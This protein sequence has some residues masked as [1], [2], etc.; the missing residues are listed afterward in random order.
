MKTGYHAVYENDFF[1][2]IDI[3]KDNGFEF[4]Q[5][6]LGV[7][8]FFLDDLNNDDLNEIKNYSKDKGIQLSFHA[9]GDNVSLFCDYPKIRKGNIGQFLSMLEKANKLDARHITFHAGQYPEF[10]KSGCA[11]DDFSQQFADYYMGVLS[12][13]ITELLN[14]TQTTLICFENSEFNSLIMKVLDTLIKDDK[15][16]YLTFDTA[17]AYTKKY[18][19]DQDV[20]Q[21]MKNY[22]ERVREIHIH[23]FNK[24]YGKHQIVGSGIVDFNLFKDFLFKDNIF[25]NFEVRPMQAAKT[26]KQL[27]FE[28]FNVNTKQFT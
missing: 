11:Y 3:A 14:C 26:S 6:D 1:E 12:E 7:P 16:L 24:E 23:D 8:T 20:F 5:F 2:A 15:N 25:M 13:N 28:M 4:V 21:F 10:K 17:K 9:P 27:L 19:I 22:S 18:E